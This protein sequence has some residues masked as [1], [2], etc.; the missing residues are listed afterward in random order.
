MDSPSSTPNEEPVTVEQGSSQV[1]WDGTP[2]HVDPAE[3]ER[4]WLQEAQELAWRTSVSTILCTTVSFTGEEETFEV[5]ASRSEVEYMLPNFRH[6]QVHLR[7]SVGIL[8]K[9]S[10]EDFGVPYL[11]PLLAADTAASPFTEQIANDQIVFTHR[12]SAVSETLRA[13]SDGC[14]TKFGLPDNCEWRVNRNS[15][16]HSLLMPHKPIWWAST[17]KPTKKPTRN[18]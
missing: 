10:D 7:A 16:C 4:I 3:L 11:S 12:H 1:L 18:C 13:L 9:Y 2:W 5:R 8:S 6:L 17:M 15:F 14:H